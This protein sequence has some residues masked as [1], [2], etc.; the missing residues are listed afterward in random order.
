LSWYDD[1]N[2]V[3]LDKLYTLLIMLS[4]T[5]DVREKIKNIVVN[6]QINY[7]RVEKLYAH[8]ENYAPILKA[9][10]SLRKRQDD[11]PV[12]EK[13]DKAAVVKVEVKHISDKLKAQQTEVVKEE[14]KESRASKSPRQKNTITLHENYSQTMKFQKG[15]INTLSSMNSSEVMVHTN[16]QRVNNKS[17]Q[18]SSEKANPNQMND[19]QEANSKLKPTSVKVAQ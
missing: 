10:K 3:E 19:G 6:N 13:T 14:L 7:D 5:K 17:N 11:T 2:D 4:K 15:T 12:K 8:K 9:L 18:K 1:Q 16:A